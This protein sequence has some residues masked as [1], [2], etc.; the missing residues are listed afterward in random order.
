MMAVAFQGEVLHDP[1]VKNS[2][3][4]FAAAVSGVHDVVQNRTVIPVIGI[5]LRIEAYDGREEQ[6]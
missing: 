6:A 2:K 5:I 4:R 3:G 1:Q